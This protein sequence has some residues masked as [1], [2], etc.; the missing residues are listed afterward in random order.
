M[1]IGKRTYIIGI[2]FLLLAVAA[3]GSYLGAF[4]TIPK[5]ESLGT[6]GGAVSWDIKLGNPFVEKGED[7]ELLLNIRIKGKEVT[8]AERS[9]V[10][11]VLV[12]DRSGSMGDRGKIEYAR[13]AAKQMIGGLGSEDRLA[14]VAYSTDVDVMYP[15]QKLRDNEAVSSVVNRILPTNSTNL[16]GGLV[17]GIA[18]LESV[19]RDGYVNRV[20]LLSDGLAN[21]GITSVAELS[22]IA[23]AAAVKGIHVTAMGLGADYD[24]NLMTN[25]A[26]YGA[27]NYYFIESPGQVAEIFEREFGRIAATVAKDPVIRL[28]LSEGVTVKEVYGYA[29]TTGKD[30]SVEIRPGDF[31]G[32]QERDILVSLNVPAGSVGKSTLASVNLD[33]YDV[34]NGGA[35][36]KLNEALSYDVTA[37]REKV[38]ANENRDVTARWISGDSAGEYYR[39]ASAYES[40]NR[41]DALSRIK[42]AYQRM[43]ELN[44]SPYT[45]E[46]TEIQEAELREALDDLSAAPASPESDEAKLLIKRQKAGAREQQK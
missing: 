37:D 39:A 46:R 22:E 43:K 21:A 33:Y 18:Q 8:I 7:R 25:L 23:S 42:A 29:Y 35:E 10:N 38:A 2:L 17:E 12:M 20:I 16:S 32:G 14:V 5:P 45:T 40:G 19:S 41:N 27:G 1:K 6:G 28:A 4:P 11:L 24:E 44:S 13:E 36:V 3:G 9:P 30:G 26:E 34:L 15:I 31:F